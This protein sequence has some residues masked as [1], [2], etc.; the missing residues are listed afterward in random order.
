[1]G[2][3]VARRVH[4]SSEL[5]LCK[6]LV[7]DL[8]RDRGVPRSLLTGSFD[9]VLASRPDLII[10]VIG[11]VEPALGFVRTSL[12]AGV[13]VVS[14]NKTL[15]S[16]HG[17]LLRRIAHERRV[18]L[19]CEA[20]VLAGVPVLAAL[21]QLRADRVTRIEGVVNGSCNYIL[22]AM[23]RG[24][25]YESALDKARGLGLVEPDPSA[26]VS[27][28]DS[29][30]K[31]CVLAA[32]CGVDL[33]PA[34]VEVTG[35]ES[36]TSED[37]ARARRSRRA[38]R[39]VARMDPESGEASVAPAL[40]RQEHPLYAVDGCDNALVIEAALAGRLVLQGPGAGPLPTASAL[41]GEAVR[42]LGA[43]PM[44][45]APGRVEAPSSAG[46]TL[47]HEI[48]WSSERRSPGDVLRT[49]RSHGG[50]LVDQAISCSRV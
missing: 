21:D 37:C 17:R 1:V 18:G 39:L 49:V 2:R 47:E 22:S 3:E 46:Q 13:P 6:V 41:L 8:A 40:V 43:P 10:E 4:E 25:S 33:S 38:V 42:L 31:L 34:R 28:R 9:A 5:S 35:I 7:R 44:R 16:H 26:D 32:A 48:A 36:V 14:A 50:E 29:A 45:P 15:M 12:E 24:L 23:A 11:G 30:E 19:G 27:G 20:S